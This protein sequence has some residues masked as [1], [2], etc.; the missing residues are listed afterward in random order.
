MAA[1]SPA[2]LIKPSTV[3]HALVRQPRSD[4]HG[5]T[6]TAAFYEPSAFLLS[7]SLLSLMKYAGDQN[8]G[9]LRSFWE[10][11]KSVFERRAE[12]PQAG[13]IHLLGKLFN[14]AMP[15]ATITL[16]DSRL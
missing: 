9:K 8:G 13:S 7:L 5:S 14:R 3:R 2:F 4:N 6:I 16:C 1:T 12:P 10:V 11:F 15:S